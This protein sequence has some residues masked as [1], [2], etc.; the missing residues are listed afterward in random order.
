VEKLDPSVVLDTQVHPTDTLFVH[1]PAQMRAAV[2]RIMDVVGHR[3][4]DICIGS[5]Y[6]VRDN[7]LVLTTWTRIAQEVTARYA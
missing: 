3:L 4:L 5:V 1:T 2:E 7:P 6:T